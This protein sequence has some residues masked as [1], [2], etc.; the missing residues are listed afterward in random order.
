[1]ID[2]V[3]FQC[4]KVSKLHCEREKKLQRVSTVLHTAMAHATRLTMILAIA[5]G[6]TRCDGSCKLSR[7]VARKMASCN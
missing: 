4:N 3:I 1:M 7:K 6:V 5:W 2:A